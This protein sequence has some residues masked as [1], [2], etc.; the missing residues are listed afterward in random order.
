MNILE[1][2]I[3]GEL[4]FIDGKTGEPITDVEALANMIKSL[5]ELQQFYEK[6]TK[7]NSAR[8]A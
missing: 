7:G 2:L 5:I 6:I 8:V 3:K 4:K 1:K